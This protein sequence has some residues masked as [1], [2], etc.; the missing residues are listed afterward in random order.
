[1]ISFRFHIVSLTAVFL[2]LA[3]GITIGAGVVDRATVDFLQRRLELVESNRLRTNQRN[4]VLDTDL[5]R[6]GRFSQEAGHR[7]VEGRL[8][9]VPVLLVGVAGVDRTVVGGFR[10]TLQGAG[11]LAGGTLW[12]TDKWAI[13]NADDAHALA[14]LLFAPPSTRPDD[15]RASGIARLAAS[16]SGAEG[17]GFLGALREA[18][19]VDFEASPIAPADLAA[20]PQPGSLFVIVSGDAARV[21]SPTLAEPLVARMVAG[22]LRTLAGQPSRTVSAAEVSEKQLASEFVVAIRSDAEIA[23]RV[24]TVD[25]LQDYRGRVAAT[26][27]LQEMLGGRTGHYGFAQGASRVLPEGGA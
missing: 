19:F 27:A 25:N 11:A 3:A 16:F 21:P 13:S 7:M 6:W 18:G 2:A 22:G 10:D 26:M 12:L 24:S 5:S 14:A 17:Q 23:P 15:L 9:G 1:M 20:L 8:R 4:D